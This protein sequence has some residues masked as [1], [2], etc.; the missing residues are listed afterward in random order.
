MEGGVGYHLEAFCVRST[1][2]GFVHCR[3]T[4]YKV[5]VT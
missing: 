1:D 3:R 2:E 4:V 5:Q